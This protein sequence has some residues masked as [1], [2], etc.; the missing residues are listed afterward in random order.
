[1]TKATGSNNASRGISARYFAS[2]PSIARS[3]RAVNQRGT[4]R[5][6]RWNARASHRSTDLTLR[7]VEL[8]PTS[9]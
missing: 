8:R 4:R 3:R 1:M 7:D 6:Q 5:F 9:S 2:L